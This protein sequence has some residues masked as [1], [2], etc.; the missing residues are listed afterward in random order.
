SAL[1]VP[2][3]PVPVCETSPPIDLT[4]LV[5]A[6]PSGG[7][8]VFSGPGVTGDQ[9]D[10]GG[11]SGAQTITVDYA[12][13]GCAASPATFNLDVVTDAS[14]AVNPVAVCENGSTVDL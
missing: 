1:T 12:I 6:V 7:A 10:P 3:G 5:S 4:T 14:I 11:L 9:F 13:G 2:V 8:F